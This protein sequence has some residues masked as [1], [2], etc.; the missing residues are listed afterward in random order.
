MEPASKAVVAA[1]IVTTIGA[2]TVALI[3]RDRSP[4]SPPAPATAPLCG[5]VPAVQQMTPSPRRGH[6][7]VPTDFKL[8]SGKLVEIPCHWERHKAD[9][10]NKY[11]PGHW[12]MSSG[13]CVWIPGEFVEG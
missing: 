9:G 3:N 13:N 5:G 7:W 8:S 2:I 6:I 10:R 1:A 12:R 4:S 11:V